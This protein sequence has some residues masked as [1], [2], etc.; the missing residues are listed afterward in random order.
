MINGLNILDVGASNWMVAGA[1]LGERDGAGHR[2]VN[3]PLR[4]VVFVSG[5][6]P[7]ARS[8][9][10]L[11]VAT[12]DYDVIFVESIAYSYSCIERVVPDLV[13]ISSE[14]DDV[15]ACELLSMLRVDCRTQG[16][17]VLVGPTFPGQD[18]PDDDPADLDWDSSAETL[19]A[20]AN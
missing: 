4:T 18:D 11:L 3:H 5:R 8:L 20:P 15:A 1:R 19:A 12:I 6:A 17:P 13:I 10:V 14:V 16:I 2:A 9:D 7:E